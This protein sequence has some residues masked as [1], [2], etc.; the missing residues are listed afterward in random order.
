MILFTFYILSDNINNDIIQSIKLNTDIDNYEIIFNSLIN[1]NKINGQYVTFLKI[2]NYDT[3][4]YN[5]VILNDIFSYL[6]NKN[7]INIFI[8]PSLIEKEK[9]SFEFNLLNTKIIECESIILSKN[10]LLKKSANTFEKILS[11]SKNEQLIELINEDYFFIK[12]NRRL[13]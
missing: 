5:T 3:C 8:I 12:Y 11:I 10:Y 7:N 9:Q 2:D 13:V 4:I 1:I 6:K